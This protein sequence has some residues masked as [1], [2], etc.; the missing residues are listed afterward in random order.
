VG[1]SRPEAGLANR[2]LVAEGYAIQVTGG[3][4]RLATLPSSEGST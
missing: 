3:T 2:A 1:L 4:Y